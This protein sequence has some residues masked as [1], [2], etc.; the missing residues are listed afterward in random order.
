M[1][2]LA[3]AAWELLH[4][5][6]DVYRTDPVTG[7]MLHRY[8]TRFGEPVRIAVTGTPG[9]GKATLLEALLPARAL[10]QASFSDGA[11][12]ADA[13]LHLS[14]DAGHAWQDPLDTP[15]TRAAPINALLVLSRADEVGGGRIDA[16]VTAKQ[17]ARQRSQDPAVGNSCMGVIAF[18][19]KIALAAK[20]LTDADFAHLA[21]MAGAPRNELDVA[22]LSTDRFVGQDFP[23]LIGSETRHAL[24]ARLG[25]HGVRLA[26]TLIR[27]GSTDRARL[28]A[29]LAR[30]S[31]LHDLREAVSHYF[32]ERREVLKAR[33][34]LVAVESALGNDSRAEELRAELERVLVSAHEF[35]ELRLLATLRMA[36]FAPEA[37][38]EAHR[39]VGGNGSHLPA[40]LG[41]DETTPFDELWALGTDA[42][43]RWQNRAD[44][45][46]VALP[47]RRA[48]R[49]VVR[50]CEGLLAEL[51]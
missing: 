12:D 49:V 37:E 24:L 42:L 50:S 29:E 14:P 20:E 26:V 34:V 1:N 8:L 48:A 19:G 44:D 22:M 16:L 43:W 7:E 36:G 41:V 30:R 25:L 40:R 9:A 5:A 27:T 39:L 46:Q 21:A 47:Q 17:L 4:R 23:A 32:V 31:G 18:S 15:V 11:E 38:A 35:R 13:Y 51:G 10:R 3:E 45:P 6:L 33:S 2:R 28:C